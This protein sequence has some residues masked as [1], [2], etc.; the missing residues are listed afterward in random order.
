M[1][2]EQLKYSS[3]QSVASQQ[4]SPEKHKLISNL[5]QEDKKPLRSLQ[6]SR[7]LG[8]MCLL[9]AQFSCAEQAFKSF[10]WSPVN[11]H[12]LKNESFQVAVKIVVF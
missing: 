4:Q 2:F 3:P 5:K 7:S 9:F 6:F 1:G 12:K 10:D 11:K 8:D